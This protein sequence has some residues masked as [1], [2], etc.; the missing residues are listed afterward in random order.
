MKLN[1]KLVWA[2]NTGFGLIGILYCW[3]GVALVD[4]FN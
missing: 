2:Y 3:E 1:I 4:E